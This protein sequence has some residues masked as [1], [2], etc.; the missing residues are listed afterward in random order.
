MVANQ[1]ITC[2]IGPLL[3]GGNAP[4]G[5]LFPGGGPMGLDIIPGGLE[6]GCGFGG[7]GPSPNSAISDMY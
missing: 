2:R 3:G 5:G 6:S 1:K 7:G 4:K